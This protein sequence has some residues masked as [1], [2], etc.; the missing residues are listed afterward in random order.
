MRTN[1]KYLLAA[2]LLPLLCACGKGNGFD[3]TG[4]FEATEVIVSAEV[5]GRIMQYDVD[6][7]S[8]LKAGQQVGYI[9]TTQLYLQKMQLTANARSVRSRAQDVSKQI[10]STREEIAKAQFEKRRNEKLLA[11]NASTQKQIDDLDSQIAVLEK[12]L[13]AQISSLQNSNTSITEESS[14]L[15]IQVAAIEDMICKSLLSSPI[16]GTVLAN[17]A[18]AGELAAPGKALF[19]VA[20]TGNM[21]LRAYITSS[22]LADVKIG[23]KVKV[24]SDYGDDIRKEYIG[25]VKWIADK[26]E[27]TPKTIQTKDER[28][29]L[30]YA[31]KIAVPNDGYI[32]IGMYGEV[33]LSE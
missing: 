13:A 1:G 15:E 25:T 18:Q 2:G 29:D 23:Q 11:S 7:G 24:F 19:K 12:K 9:D 22:Q 3:A 32:K 28:A 30:V 33:K 17:Y 27:F 6:E 10:A 20:D 31:V 21:Y 14:A 26:A 16:D 5:N 8:L 4:T